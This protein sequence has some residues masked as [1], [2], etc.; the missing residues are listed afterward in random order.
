LGEFGLIRAGYLVYDSDKDSDTWLGLDA[1]LNPGGGGG[2]LAV[3]I[4]DRL[5][6]LDP[7]TPYVYLFSQFGMQPGWESSGG[8]EEWAVAR[9]ETAA[10]S[11]V[12][13][14]ASLLLLGTGIVGLGF[15]VMRRKK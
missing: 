11:E 8:F 15:L 6:S 1:S 4:P 14:P 9:P 10:L 5:F 2:D 13:E 3:Y 7:L 12:P